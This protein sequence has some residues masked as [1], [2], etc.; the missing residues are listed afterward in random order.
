MEPVQV[1]YRTREADPGTTLSLM[2]L[3]DWP[4][5]FA[6]VDV[7]SGAL[8]RGNY[9]RHPEAPEQAAKPFDVVRVVIAEDPDGPDPTQPEAVAFL[10]PP[11]RLGGM[12]RR[13]A[14]RLL[15]PLLLP[16]GEV[17]MGFP[18][19]AAQYWTIPGDRP[20][21]AVLVSERPPTVVT[22][23]DGDVACRFGWGGVEL[24]LG[25]D[26]RRLRHAMVAGDWSR[27]AG[28]TLRQVLGYEPALV[29][30]AL[31]APRAGRCYKVVAG[32]LPQP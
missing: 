8:V 31:S 3:A 11:E 24:E 15:D 12:R 28:G 27:L 2:V 18:G 14:R 20:S 26:D 13:R 6:A 10:A 25:V 29:V 17:P 16:A 22:R 1:A 7:S 5:G 32:L 23:A 4:E 19:S 9:P 21:L 30:L